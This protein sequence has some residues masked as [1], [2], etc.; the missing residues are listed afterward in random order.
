MTSCPSPDKLL[1]FAAG[2]LDALGLGAIEAHI[3]AC[4]DCRAALSNFARGDV[5]PSFGRYRIDTVLGSGGMGIVYR[6]WDPQLARA[7]AIKVVRRASDDE[8]GRARLIREAQ[9]LARLSHPN[10]CHVYD[11]GS[12]DEEVWVAMELIDGVS[13]REWPNREAFLDVLLGAARG[14]A[15]AH[16][17]G[18]V[19][20]DI[21]PENVLVTRDGRAIVTDFG[22]A[23][24]EDI[25][26]PNASTLSTDPH[27]TATGAIAGT[28][29]YIAPEQLTGDPIDARVDQFAFAVMAWE[30]LTG[31]KPFPIIIALRVDAVRAGVTPPPTLPKH[32]AVALSK[33]MA[34]A[35][36]DRFPTMR[37]LIEAMEAPPRA[38]ART[39]AG[40]EPRSRGPIYA[41]LGLLAMTGAAIT[42][43]QWP[44]HAHE[45]VPP[46]IIVQKTIAPPPPQPPP[47]APPDAAALPD[48]AAIAVAPPAKQPPPHKQTAAVAVAKQPPSST[49]PPVASTGSG[50]DTTQKMTSEQGSQALAVQKRHTH[51][52]PERRDA[53]IATMDAFCYLPYDVTHPDKDLPRPVVDWGKVTSITEETGHLMGDDIDSN[54]LTIQG[55]RGTYR[56]MQE[57]MTL[58][59]VVPAQVGDWMALCADREESDIYRFPG[60]PTLPVESI[61]PLRSPPRI[62]ELAKYKP[63]HIRE[64][65]MT[66]AGANQ[67]HNL[68]EDRAYVIRAKVVDQGDGKRLKMD[69]YYMD[70]PPSIKLEVGKPTWVVVDHLHYEDADDSGKKPFVVRAVA[71]LNG[72][73]FPG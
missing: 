9:A 24:G 46:P 35:P 40:T 71:V 2:Q 23:R 26:D 68:H 67:H 47:V 4:T 7:I 62:T 28:P 60:G 52:G 56:V 37:E 63:L 33:A 36:R 10:V 48:A 57:V 49:I 19:H 70:V 55:A 6:A 50:S 58:N 5:P 14:I 38:R 21:K 22:L 12:E 8:K 25:I 20:R 39:K 15:A 44:R 61:V 13:L 45:Q 73:M 65:A 30:L 18:L 51:S 41:S 16:D 42:A 27:L 29:A 34:A 59:Y 53:A 3:D 69:R 17:A 64:L 11:V 54:I 72:D 32:L 43:W 1:A 66:A 31:T